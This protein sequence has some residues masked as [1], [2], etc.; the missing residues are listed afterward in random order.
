MSFFGLFQ[1]MSGKPKSSPN[2]SLGGSVPGSSAQMTVV[3]SLEHAPTSILRAHGH[4]IPD[5]AATPAKSPYPSS[6]TPAATRRRQKQVVVRRKPVPPPSPSTQIEDRPLT[7][8]PKFSNSSLLLA[9]AGH[10]TQAA[11]LRSHIPLAS[12]KPAQNQLLVQHHVTFDSSGAQS[13]PH[14][15]SVSDAMEVDDEPSTK[16]VATAPIA[17]HAFLANA[18]ES[19]STLDA[20]GS[21]FARSYPASLVALATP[22]APTTTIGSGGHALAAPVLGAAAIPGQLAALHQPFAVQPTIP[23]SQSLFALTSAIAATPAVTTLTAASVP[24][25][26]PTALSTSLANAT[27]AGVNHSATFTRYRRLTKR[28]REDEPRKEVKKMRITS[29]AQG[30][31]PLYTRRDAYTPGV[32]VPHAPFT[33]FD[34]LPV[35][36]AGMGALTLNTSELRIG[37]SGSPSSILGK[38]L[39]HGESGACGVLREFRCDATGGDDD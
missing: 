24:P 36:H 7:P 18:A 1:W 10:A 32:P 4:G 8:I 14:T 25:S 16:T 9:A 12:S 35:P 21:S 19:V 13:M 23:S 11:R 38:A 33:I 26:V 37:I 5:A 39:Q 27:A 30:A 31:V 29:L 34:F 20:S 6:S 15:A 2:T 17:S 22:G 28:V 3:E